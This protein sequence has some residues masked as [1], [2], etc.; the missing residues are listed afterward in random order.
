MTADTFDTLILPVVAQEDDNWLSRMNANPRVENILGPR[1]A[2]IVNVITQRRNVLAAESRKLTHRAQQ[3]DKL[4]SWIK[5]AREWAA[6]STQQGAGLLLSQQQPPHPPV[7]MS[8]KITGTK[9]QLFS[10]VL[11]QGTLRGISLDS[12]QS[13]LPLFGGDILTG[14]LEQQLLPGDQSL[15]TSAHQGMVRMG[16]VSA[17]LKMQ[18]EQMFTQGQQLQEGHGNK[19]MEGM[20][21]QQQLAPGPVY[22]PCTPG[23]GMPFASQTHPA[24]RDSMLC[25]HSA[26]VAEHQPQ[27]QSSS[28]GGGLAGTTSA[29]RRAVSFQSA[30]IPFRGM[31]GRF[32]NTGRHNSGNSQ[33]LSDQTGRRIPP[34]PEVHDVDKV[35]HQSNPELYK[36][37]FGDKVKVQ[38]YVPP[39]PFLDDDG[40]ERLNGGEQPGQTF[41]GSKSFT[42]GQLSAHEVSMD[43]LTLQPT[44]DAGRATAE[45]QGQSNPLSDDQ[46]GLTLNSQDFSQDVVLSNEN[47]FDC[48][49]R[50]LD[51]QRGNMNAGAAGVNLSMGTRA[52]NPA[53][54][55]DFVTVPATHPDIGGLNRSSTIAPS[56]STAPTVQGRLE[57]VTESSFTVVA[58][59]I[60]TTTQNHTHSVGSDK[61]KEL[62][63]MMNQAIDEG[64]GSQ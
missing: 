53:D 27:H 48:Q 60:S 8:S 39:S 16:T 1:G 7:T 36:R 63:I 32:T 44:I 64:S 25:H 4:L 9:S 40:E 61:D 49:G 19:F 34:N 58:A 30:D 11:P 52:T 5:K 13:S 45:A 3:M 23:C 38:P 54:V 47:F 12:M 50:N 20:L 22:P 62:E 15:F 24:V 18:S 51:T 29:K 21:P 14:Q 42:S 31:A 33:R 56:Q 46:I 41:R 6:L 17:E 37:L 35:V 2:A 59:E 28:F 43:Q 26:G 10:S 55:H 57:G